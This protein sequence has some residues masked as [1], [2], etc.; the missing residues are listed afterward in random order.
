MKGQ[1]MKRN[2]FRQ[3]RSN[4]EWFTLHIFRNGFLFPWC[5][6]VHLPPLTLVA[7]LVTPLPAECVGVGPVAGEP[8]SI[9]D[10]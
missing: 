9:G 10:Y 1:Q 3:I 6:R 2:I 8:C 4:F 5:S 7:G